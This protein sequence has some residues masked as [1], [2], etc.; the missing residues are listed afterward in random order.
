MLGG[1]WDLFVG[2]SVNRQIWEIRILNAI[3]EVQQLSDK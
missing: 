3:T 1:G 2:L